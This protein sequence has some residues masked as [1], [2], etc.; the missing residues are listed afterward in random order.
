MRPCVSASQPA[1]TSESPSAAVVT[2]STSADIAGVTS[3][4][5][6]SSG[7]SACGENSSAKVARPA[8]KSATEAR[9][10]PGSP[11]R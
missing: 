1:G 7:S 4:C 11:E 6:L 9:R 5:S 10:K 8:A 2:A 3:N